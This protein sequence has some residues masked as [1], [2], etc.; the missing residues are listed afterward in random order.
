MLLLC[1]LFAALFRPLPE[2]TSP[3]VNKES[4]SGE[5]TTQAAANKNGGN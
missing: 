5:V 4:V 3:S 2:V 1:V